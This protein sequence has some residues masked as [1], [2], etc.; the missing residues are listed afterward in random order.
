MSLT[1]FNLFF[2]NLPPNL[3][4]EEIHAF[5]SRY[6]EIQNLLVNRNLKGDNSDFGYVCFKTQDG[7]S[8]ARFEG[9]HATIKG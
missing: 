1:K 8:K 6:G 9:P 4:N 5:F 2:S 7:A 3:S